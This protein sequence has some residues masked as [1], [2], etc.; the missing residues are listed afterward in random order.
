MDCS[1]CWDDNI[2]QYGLMNQYLEQ[3]ESLAVTYRVLYTLES[4]PYITPEGQVLK[5]QYR[6]FVELHQAVTSKLEEIKM[7]IWEKE[8]QLKE[9]AGYVF[10]KLHFP[11]QLL[12]YNL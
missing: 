8:E 7:K 10:C 12:T 9:A 6:A 5:N 3:L 1:I 11:F 4:L 2:A